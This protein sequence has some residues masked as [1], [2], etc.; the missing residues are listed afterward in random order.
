M[1]IGIAFLKRGG[2]TLI[3]VL[4]TVVVIGVLAA[5]VIPAVTSQVSAGDSSRVI[6][7]LNNVRTGIENFDI[8]VRQ[9]PGD[10]DDLVNA[11][12][13]SA[14]ST[15]SDVDADITG[16][17]YLGVANWAGPYLEASLPSDVTS[18][19]LPSFSAP[20]FPTGF[21]A[22]VNNR[23]LRCKIADTGNACTTSSPDYVAI[24]LDN[25]TPLQASTLNDHIDGATEALSST[26]GK[27]RVFTSGTTTAYYYATPFK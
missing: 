10:I 5:V 1:K 12:G 8:A 24:E 3:E 18:S 6:S 4:V 26:S 15:G 19:T 9:F 20:A 23:L 2:F 14:S 25:L 16:A 17:T 22:T 21:S 7:D 27:F 11:P 13:T